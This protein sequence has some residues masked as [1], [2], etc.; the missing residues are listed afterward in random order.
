MPRLLNHDLN[1]DLNG[2][3]ME[4]RFAIQSKINDMYIPVSRIQFVMS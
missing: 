3:R 1:H 4:R 2:G